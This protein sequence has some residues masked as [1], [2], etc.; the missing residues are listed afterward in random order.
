VT[1][2]LDDLIAAC[3]AAPDDDAPRLVWADA[4]GG[5]RGELVVL[6]C[7]LAREDLP[8]AEA[9]AL[10]RRHDE[11][12]AEH[13]RAWSGFVDERAVRRCV[14]RRG[15]VESVEADMT[16]IGVQ[17]IAE[18]APLVQ[19]LHVR[20]IA[21]R[22]DYREEAT[23]SSPEPAVV[24]GALLDQPAIRQLPGI[25]ISDAYLHESD[26]DTEWDFAITSH[27]DAVM[28]LVASSGLRVRAL[29]I[30]DAF[31]PRGMHALVHSNVLASIESLAFEYGEA[32]PAQAARLLAALP[33]L[34]TLDVH[35]AFA[36]RDVAPSL[37][38][39]V[40][41]LRAARCEANDLAALATSQVAG[42]LERL[43]LAGLEPVVFA[44]L[45]P[46]FEQLR[47]LDIDNTSIGYDPSAI[48]E[49]IDALVHAPLPA[50]R[51]LRPFRELTD[52]HALA[53]AEAFGPQLACLDLYAQ[54]Q[55]QCIDELRA[56]VAGHVRAGAW[57]NP[58]TLLHVG[59]NTRE[60][61]LRYGLVA[62]HR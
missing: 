45:L 27:G 58:K 25:E 37:P 10:I 53:I 29:A 52:D 56:K 50:L 8:P 30:R 43:S 1:R 22:I 39:S 40:V 20:G 60:P 47:V 26:G 59:I 17:R 4:V 61:W 13:G 44:R 34:R 11:L 41:E 38:R 6:Q 42:T 14:F 33:N 62:V 31:T 32:D 7:R 48:A 23:P 55:L 2:E 9:G 54:E 21:Q 19:S 28:D 18:R 15:F 51:E 3:R 46:A 35:A 36:L 12:L 49:T 5:E 16:M 57:R 24:L